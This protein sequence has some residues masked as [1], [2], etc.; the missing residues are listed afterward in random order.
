MKCII[1][2]MLFIISLGTG[3][4]RGCSAKENS[5]FLRFPHTFT[6]CFS[7][8]VI[9]IHAYMS[10]KCNL[11]KL[12][13]VLVQISKC[14]SPCFLNVF[15]QIKKSYLSKLMNVLVKIPYDLLSE[16]HNTLVFNGQLYW[17]QTRVYNT[18]NTKIST[19]LS[20]QSQ[21]YVIISLCIDY[22]Y[23]LI[24]SIFEND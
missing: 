20:S 21:C 17:L 2:Q 11:S 18:Y 15:V 3:V 5:L 4:G 12:K 6:F 24:F 10:I 19:Y 9:C 22:V 13:I 16:M 8:N 23:I 14:I 7:S 1:P